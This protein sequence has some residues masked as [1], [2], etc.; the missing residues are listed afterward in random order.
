[1][2]IYLF[3][4]F[5]QFSVLYFSLLFI[6]VYV[7]IHEKFWLIMEFLIDLKHINMTV[8]LDIGH[9]DIQKKEQSK[10]L[11]Y[12]RFHF[13]LCNH[14]KT[15]KTL[16][17]LFI[18]PCHLYSLVIFIFNKLSQPRT[19][20]WVQNETEINIGFWNVLLKD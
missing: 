13:L 1:M 18:F 4:I 7:A 8:S 14:S 17:F 12:K 2:Y 19:R 15:Q 5:C 6:N 3:Y 20:K 16:S 9:E 11:L 10:F